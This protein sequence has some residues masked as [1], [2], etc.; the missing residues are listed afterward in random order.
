MKKILSVA[1]I[2][3]GTV[4]DHIPVGMG[5]QI[6]KLL[7]LAKHQKKV[8]LGLNLPSQ[9]MG[10]KD[11]IKVEERRISKEEADQ[12]ALFAPQAKISIIADFRLEKKFTVSLP[13]TIT[14]ILDC[15]NGRCITNHERVTTRF[16]VDCFGKNV[17][18]RCSYCEKSFNHA[19][20]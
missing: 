14:K 15:P 16:W 10:F 2:E 11:L 4:I 1:A 7:G 19:A 5:L 17:S 3:N 12:I 13:K 20:N 9:S 18:L 8:T 6:V